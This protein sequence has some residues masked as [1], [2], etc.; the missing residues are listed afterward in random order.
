MAEEIQEIPLGIPEIQEEPNAEIVEDAIVLEP[1]PEQPVK[2]K[3]K[4]RPKGSSNKGPSRPRAKKTQIKEAPVEEYSPPV[5]EP[6]SPERN[7]KMP[8]DPNS[9]DIAA[10]MLK[11]LQDQTYSRQARKQRLYQSWFQ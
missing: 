9:S 8:T 6:S 7:L 1:A 5:Y 2:P 10:A 4:G 11:L 3:P